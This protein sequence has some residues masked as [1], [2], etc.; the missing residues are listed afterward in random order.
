M[1]PSFFL[2]NSRSLFPKLDDLTALL[3]RKPVDIIAITES[4]LHKHI[5]SLLSINGYNLFRKD[6]ASG[7]GGGVCVFIKNDIP[8]IRRVDL[9]SENLECLW[10]ILQPKRLPRP[11]SGIAICVVYHP[12]GLAVP[13]HNDLND[14]VI[15]TIDQLQNKH[16][17]YGLVILGDFNDFEIRTLITSQNLKQLVDQPT[18]ESAILDL[19]L[20]NVH[21]LFNCPK[22]LTP[23]GSSDHNILHWLPF[24]D[25]ISSHDTQVKSV[26]SVVR[27]YPKSG[28]DAF[29]R[30][31]TTH[32]WFRE[33]DPIP[34][35][36][37]LVVSFTNRLTESIDR[38]F[39]Q[40][41]LTRHHNDKPRITPAIKQ[42]VKNRQKAFH[43][44]NTTLW[45]SLKYKVQQ[46]INARKISYYKTMVQ[47]LK[48]DDCHMWW[49]IVNK[50]AG[51]SE[52]N[53][54]FSLEQNGRTLYQSELVNFLNVFY[55]SVNINIPPL[56]LTALPAFLPTKEPVP[57]VQPQ[58]VFKKL[59]TVKTFK[60][61][62]PDNASCRLLKDFAYELAEPVA[63]IF[64]ASLT[65]G[66]VPATWKDSDIIPIP[67]PS[68]IHPKS[69]PPICEGDTRPISL[70]SCLSKVLEDFV[71]RWMI[72]DI[73]DKID[74]KQFGCMKCTST[75]YCLLD[76]IHTWLGN[77]ESSEK[78]LRLC[79]LDFAK[80]FDRIG[81][82]LLISK[83]LGLGVRSSLLPW[84]ISFLTN[85]RHRGKL[86]GGEISNWLPVKAGVPK[87]GPILFLAMIN[88]LD[89]KTRTMD[90]WK[91]VDDISTSEYITK[92]NISKIQ[93][94]LDSINSWASCNF[95]KLNPKKCKEL[96]VCFLMET[97][98]LSPLLIDGYANDV[99]WSH[100]AWSGYSK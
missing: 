37:S 49:K 55:A 60:S 46:K 25:S 91:F 99:V 88:D 83:L 8:C 4:W 74:P 79:F 16:P 64:N 21:K 89:V 10:L 45:R 13:E 71:V 33:L 14:Y 26:K 53:R 95:R 93:S 5:D 70:T 40:Q 81:H 100:I 52:K 1:L 7:R 92:G 9:E 30:W 86:G 65:S 96:R 17:D 50:M 69:H 19:I 90:I 11:L 67:N 98:E 72:T 6:R 27:R 47:H 78:H 20:T 2:L 32:D 36:D 75:T 15:N 22:V 42:L 35:V 97:P 94:G 48:K 43:S 28:I 63:T 73:E 84:I 80:A 24:V 59:S 34:T 56:D 29:G 62:G 87:L 57:T 12:P 23:L 39:P 76:M 18:R 31:I 51:K 82:N 85:H 44:Q 58:E 61:H 41:T 66:I 54:S 38:I 3:S 68:K 77:L